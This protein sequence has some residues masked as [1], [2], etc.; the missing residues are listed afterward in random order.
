MGAAHQR[1]R[2]GNQ[3]RV[4][5]GS[6]GGRRVSIDHAHIKSDGGR[7]G[8]II[9][10]AS[11]AMKEHTNEHGVPTRPG[12]HRGSLDNPAFLKEMLKI[13]VDEREAEEAEGRKAATR[14]V[15][16]KAAVM[17]AKRLGGLARGRRLA[18]R[19]STNLSTSDTHTSFGCGKKELVCEENSVVMEKSNAIS[20]TL[21]AIRTAN[22]GDGDGATM[23]V[24]AK[25]PSFSFW[26]TNVSTSA[27]E[28]KWREK[29]RKQLA[30]SSESTPRSATPMTPT[31]S[32][33]EV[34]KEDAPQEHAPRK[35][36]CRQGRRVTR[37]NEGEAAGGERRQGCAS[38]E[39]LP[40]KKNPPK[41][42]ISQRNS[43]SSPRSVSNRS[44]SLAPMPGG[45][46]AADV[47]AD[48]ARRQKQVA[49]M[50]ASVCGRWIRAFEKGRKERK[51]LKVEDSGGYA[52]VFLTRSSTRPSN[53]LGI[54]EES[55]TMLLPSTAAKNALRLHVTASEG[56]REVRA[57]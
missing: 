32:V 50:K 20:S 14:A 55:K 45:R 49:R 3:R 26:P 29:E 39:R 47:V 34:Q 46:P 9:Y 13:L 17:D 7:R 30:E 21:G 19:R 12:R 8:S 43:M 6:I 5:R 1:R 23:L 25:K 24:L 48:Q 44:N 22:G 52:R 28:V 56:Q 51:Q 41:L 53:C 10:V 57:R 37:G 16:K 54:R 35:G 42:R 11:Q 15:M 2:S 36:K 40:G 4:R 27:H 38:S 18:R 33:R 31:A